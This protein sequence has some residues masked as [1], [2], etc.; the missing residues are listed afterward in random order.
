MQ[1]VSD[2]LL[3]LP[4]FLITA[5]KKTTHSSW[6]LG[7]WWVIRAHSRLYWSRLIDDQCSLMCSKALMECLQLI[8]YKGG[9]LKGEAMHV[10]KRQEKKGDSGRERSSR[11]KTWGIRK[12]QKKEK[13]IE[14]KLERKERAGMKQWVWNLFSRPRSQAA[15]PQWRFHFS[16]FVTPHSAHLRFLLF[17]TTK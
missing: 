3:Q 17:A 4:A 6:D 2:A 14:K 12:D 15:R 9:R 11:R 8:L 13:W 16:S 1:T 7:I 5:R 10:C